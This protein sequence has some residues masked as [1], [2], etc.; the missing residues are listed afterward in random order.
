MY[1]SELSV[2]SMLESIAG[3]APGTGIAVD[4]AI[5][6][7]GASDRRY[8]SSRADGLRV[9]GLGRLVYAATG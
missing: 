2:L 5:D 7:A 4:Y 9:G 1:L 6:P 3:L 8:F